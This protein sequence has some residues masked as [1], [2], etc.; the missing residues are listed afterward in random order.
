MPWRRRCCSWRRRGFARPRGAHWPSSSSSVQRWCLG[1]P[2][3]SSPRCARRK[4]RVYLV[5]VAIMVLFLLA[6]RL[7][8]ANEYHEDFRHIFAALVPF[9][10]CYAAVVAN[11]SRYSKLLNLAG[12][13][14]ALLMIICSLAFFLR[15]PGGLI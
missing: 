14:L 2:G 10:M 9:C 8:A 15:V 3:Y 11:S 5:S 6:F 4:Y 1:R 7:R 12:T 13:A